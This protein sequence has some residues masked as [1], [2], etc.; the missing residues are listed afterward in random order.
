MLTPFIIAL[1][2]GFETA[3]AVSIL[4]IYLRK[5]SRERL[6]PAVFVGIGLGVLVSVAGA[7]ALS[8]LY[9][10]EESALEGPLMLVAIVLVLS[11]VIWMWRTSMQLGAQVTRVVKS[12]ETRSTLG[13][14]LAMGGFAFIL[15]VR[16]GIELVVFLFAISSATQAAQWVAASIAGVLVSVVVCVAVVRGMLGVNVL[17]FFKASAVVLLIFVVQLAV[18]AVHELVEHSM[19]PNPGPAVMA[20]VDGVEHTHLFANIAVGAFVL[21]IPYALISARRGK[22]RSR[23]ASIGAPEPVTPPLG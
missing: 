10:S 6:L 21:L 3:I 1:R 20:F 15:V 2:E 5:T 13:S 14:V 7:F 4:I 9:Q 16:E 22:L 8:T 12:A 23:S 11:M 17:Q 19:M 18:G